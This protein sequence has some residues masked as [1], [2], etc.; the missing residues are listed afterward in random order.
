MSSIIC[1]TLLHTQTPSKAIVLS[2]SLMDEWGCANGQSIK[3]EIGNKSMIARVARMKSTGNKIILSPNVTRQLYLPYTGLTRATFFNKRLKLGPVIGILTTGY[4]GNPAQPFGAR[5]LLFRSFIQAGMS[6]R[7]FIYVFTPQ[8]VDWQNRTIS[9]WYF[10]KD[11]KGNMRWV[12]RTSPFPDV[13]YERVPNRKAES[14]PHVQSCL[15]RLKESGQCKIFNQ[16]FFNKWSIHVWLNNHPSTAEFIPETYLSPSIQTLHNMLEKHQM[17]Y[18]KPSGGSLGLGIFRITRHPKEGYFC[19][20]HQGEKN[21]LH[22][23]HS[24]EKLIQH[25]FGSSRSGRFKKYLVQQGIRLIKYQN[26]PVDFRVHMHKDRTGQWRVVAIGSKAA[27]PGSVTTH[28]R[29]GGSVLSTDDLLH[30]VFKKSAKEVEASIKNTAIL[31]AQVLEQQVNAPLG[32]LGMDMG[33]DRNGRVWLFEIN[34]KPGRHI[35][36]HPSLREAGWQSAKFITDYSL[37]LANFI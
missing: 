36:L 16:G 13:I 25:Y 24:L 2:Q 15:I 10:I 35:F 11:S 19:R 6:E 18:L 8:M 32:E 26:R 7:P 9:G 5:S 1:Q 23:F 20:F 28:I 12:Q 27:G 31:I 29:T 30:R 34:S 14:L 33:V 37:K 22:R 4:T 17:V 21:V 3:V